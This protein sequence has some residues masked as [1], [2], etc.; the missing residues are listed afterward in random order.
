MDFHS[1]T[2]NDD[3]SLNQ[4]FKKH[5][6]VGVCMCTWPPV[7]E[8]C[9]NNEV[10]VFQPWTVTPPHLGSAAIVALKL[11]L[12]PHLFLPFFWIFILPP[13]SYS[14]PPAVPVHSQSP[15][16]FAHAT[17]IFSHHEASPTLTFPAPASLLHSS[18]LPSLCACVY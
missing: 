3:S 8:L 16:Y 7:R 2:Q 6:G 4:V 14:P 5:L 10:V 18:L 15:L 9:P 11:S 13:P 17:H 12:P 1:S